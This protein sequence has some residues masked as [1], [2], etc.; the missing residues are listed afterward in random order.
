MNHFFSYRKRGMFK[1]IISN[2]PQST[3][4]F[5]FLKKHFINHLVSALFGCHLRVCSSKVL[6]QYFVSKEER[7][8]V[9]MHCRIAPRRARL[10][11]ILS[12]CFDVGQHRNFL[13]QPRAVSEASIMREQWHEQMKGD[14]SEYESFLCKGSIPSRCFVNN[15]HQRAEK[16]TFVHKEACN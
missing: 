13:S 2:I 4:I 8:C 3:L 1:F 5:F 9:A 7:F 11:L 15:H 10:K 16:Y 6:R 14:N 12:E